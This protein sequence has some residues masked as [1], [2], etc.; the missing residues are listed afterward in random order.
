MKNKTDLVD[1]DYIHFAL[2]GA[3]HEEVRTK[4][5]VLTCDEKK[6]ITNRLAVGKTLVELFSEI[7]LT[8]RRQLSSQLIPEFVSGEVHVC[9]PKVV[10]VSRIKSNEVN[11]RLE[12]PEGAMRPNWEEIMKKNTENL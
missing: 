8:R 12:Y 11:L 6:Q 4:V 9:S 5:T 7:L 10:A 1:A 2:C 3:F